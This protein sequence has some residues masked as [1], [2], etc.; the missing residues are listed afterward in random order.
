MKGGGGGRE[1]KIIE[2]RRLGRVEYIYI[3]GE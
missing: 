1:R 2:K 3:P